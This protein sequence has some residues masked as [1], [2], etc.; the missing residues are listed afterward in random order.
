MTRN[1]KP[2]LSPD[3]LTDFGRLVS[4]LGEWGWNFSVSHLWPLRPIDEAT[5]RVRA[6][7]R[8]GAEMVMDFHSPD[9]HTPKTF[10]RG[11]IRVRRP[12]RLIADRASPAQL[13]R[14]LREH[15]P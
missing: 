7:G 8:N 9:G 12:P 2:L 3:D 10:F 14:F 5:S 15:R 11:Q 6:Q 1:P 4:A 13:A